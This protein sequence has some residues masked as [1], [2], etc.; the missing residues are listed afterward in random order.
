MSCLLGGMLL[1]ASCDDNLSDERT[2][3]LE[4]YYAESLRLSSPQVD[5]D[6]IRR[7]SDKVAIYAAHH[8]HAVRTP[9]YAKI[10]D[11]IRLSLLHLGITFNPDWEGEIHIGF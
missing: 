8:P 3:E 11:N 1:F 4:N 9:L 7:F 5:A 10:Q 2:A 6:S